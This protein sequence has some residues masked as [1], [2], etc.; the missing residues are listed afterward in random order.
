MTRGGGGVK[1]R[2][3]KVWDR[4][5]H[6]F[7]RPEIVAQ[8]VVEEVVER[9]G[10][11]TGLPPSRAPRVADDEAPLVHVVADRED[12]VSAELGFTRRGHRDDAAVRDGGTLE[13]LV[14]GEAERERKTGREA[15]LH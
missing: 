3:P 9:H 10:E 1:R 11:I 4:S 13:A 8:R 12:R 14:H 7:H 2:T 5:R 15:S 6:R